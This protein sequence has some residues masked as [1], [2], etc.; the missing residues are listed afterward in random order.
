M[1]PMTGLTGVIEVTKVIGVNVPPVLRTS[2]RALPE[3]E[4][5]GKQE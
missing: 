2:R 4:K 3:T 1:T 5:L